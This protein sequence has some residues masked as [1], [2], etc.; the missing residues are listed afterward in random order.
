MYG[1]FDYKTKC[2]ANQHRCTYLT[3]TS[4]DTERN[5]TVL[6][7]LNFQSFGEYVWG[8]RCLPFARKHY[9]R[10]PIRRHGTFIRHTPFIR[11][12]TF[13]KKWA[14]PFNWISMSKWS[15]FRYKFVSIN[16]HLLYRPRHMWLIF[17]PI[18][19]SSCVPLRLFRTPLLIGTREYQ[20]SSKSIISKTVKIATLEYFSTGTE[21]MGYHSKTIVELR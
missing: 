4:L 19:F 21:I 9:S 8:E 3:C 14:V 10:V 1:V 15:T 20:V 16:L 12:N 6:F 18:H 17:R 7:K 13:S 11:P 2:I 5:L